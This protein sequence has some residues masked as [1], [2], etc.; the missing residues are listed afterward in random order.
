MTD[1]D[2]NN[3]QD[4]NAHLGDSTD[5]TQ[6]TQA[7]QNSSQAEN[8]ESD[9]ISSSEKLES[10]NPNNKPNNKPK[11]DAVAV[12]AKDVHGAR[13][14][15][16]DFFMF[17]ALCGFIGFV[18][19]GT[20]LPFLKYKPKIE[21]TQFHGSSLKDALMLS[22]GTQTV[23]AAP[24]EGNNPV[25]TG[26][27]VERIISEYEVQASQAGLTSDIQAQKGDGKIEVSFDFQQP[28]GTQKATTLIEPT[29]DFPKNIVLTFV[30]SKE[31]GS[32]VLQQ[33]SRDGKD[34]STGEMF[35]ELVKMDGNAPSLAQ[36]QYMTS[37][38]IFELKNAKG[39]PAAFLDNLQIFPLTAKNAMQVA[40]TEEGKLRTSGGKG[41]ESYPNLRIVGIEPS[42]GVFKNR[43]IL[44]SGAP[45]AAPCSSHAIIIDVPHHKTEISEYKL[46]NANPYLGNAQK[47]FV[48]GGFC[49]KDENGKDIMP[50]GYR[51]ELT[52]NL[53]S[54]D[55]LYQKKSASAALPPQA[56][57]IE[58]EVPAG[59]AWRITSPTRIASPLASGSA[60]V[61]LACRPGGGVSISLSGIPAPGGGSETGARITF[62]GTG[63]GASAGMKYIS[64]AGSYELAEITRPLEAKQVLN[65]LKGGGIINVSGQGAK[66]SFPSPGSAAV[67]ALVG[68]CQPIQNKTAQAKPQTPAANSAT[69]PTTKPVAKKE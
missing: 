26:L 68:K 9:K 39:G 16:K 24:I 49:D 63:A 23:L 14:A 48:M 19:G 21:D 69:K 60:L 6:N 3:S 40:F 18:T 22:I 1:K 43:L 28:S 36:G 31:P 46:L 64:T 57:I 52:Y 11:S 27:T 47:S 37:G 65:V 8:K 13:V 53:Q 29:K 58:K 42:K 41:S 4:A 61:S 15:L 62:S 12:R 38:G 7:Y 55:I 67:N 35:V 25:Q 2:K 30:A 10:P 59:G 32:I 50:K 5:T 44:V 20:I 33:I 54:G 45:N 34:L 66:S 17:G 56:P 51:V